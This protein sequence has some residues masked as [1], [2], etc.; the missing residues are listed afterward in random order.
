[1]TNVFYDELIPWYR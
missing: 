1:M